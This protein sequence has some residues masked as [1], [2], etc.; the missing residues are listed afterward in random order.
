[1][2]FIFLIIPASCSWNVDE[3]AVA[4]AA[5]LDYALTLEMEAI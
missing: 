2:A 5:M 3:M 4:E 1:M